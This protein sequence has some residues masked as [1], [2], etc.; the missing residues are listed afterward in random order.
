MM[1]QHEGLKD[2]VLYFDPENVFNNILI[3]EV[4]S[5]ILQSDFVPELMPYQYIL[6]LACYQGLWLKNY[7]SK[8]SM[9]LYSGQQ[10][11]VTT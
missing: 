11:T 9:W 5:F 10:L 2:Y 7:I 1:K 6:Y 4:W 3:V 8:L